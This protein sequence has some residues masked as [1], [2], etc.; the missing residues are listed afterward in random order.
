[1][2]L[3]SEVMGWMELTIAGWYDHLNRILPAKLPR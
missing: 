1:M 3:P 2:I